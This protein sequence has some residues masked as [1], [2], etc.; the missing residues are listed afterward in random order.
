MTHSPSSRLAEFAST[1]HYDDIPGEVVERTQWLFLDWYA[2]AVAGCNARSPVVFKKFAREMG[3]QSGPCEIIGGGPGSSALFAA[4]ANGAASH[5]VEQDDLH[6]SSIL[7]PATVVFP[8]ILA[9]AQAD[10][11]ISGRDFLVA[12][13]AGY[14][15]GIRVGEFL[16][17][18]HYRIFHM[19]GTAGTIASAMAAGRLLGLDPDRML[20]A[21]GSA[22]TQAAGLWEFLK[23]AADSKQLHTAKACAD[24][25]VA[26]WTAQAGLTGAGTILEGTQ[27]MASGMMGG[28]D[29]GKITDRLGSRW[30]LME[31]SFKYHASCRHTHPA[32]DAMLKLREDRRFEMED[33]ASVDSYVYRAAK[34]VLGAVDVP[35]TIHQSKFS[36]GFVLA[37]IAQ[38]G[39]AGVDD[40]SEQALNDPEI[41]RFREKVSM[42][43]DDEIEG[44]YPERWGTR[45]E[46]AL[47]S[48]ETLSCFVDNPKGD[49]DNMLKREE[50]ED[51]V[52]RLVRYG[53]V[54][55]QE[56]IDNIIQSVWKLTEK[57][58][59]TS[60]FC[61]MI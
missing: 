9:L 16:G 17:P 51:K 32:A 19:T 47:R 58:S 6:N 35:E 4:M 54:E 11:R 53:G 45:V 18:S 22:G 14:E 61:P 44:H 28:G 27:G 31:T 40:F 48:G 15:C 38:R 2:S 12:A 50:L 46:V 5:V 34:D 21:L 7:H 24:G 39:T 25:I 42:S 8:P 1:L 52:S 59:F 37:L 33:V 3:P 26:A 36:M 29:T 20:D 56:K 43:I 49:P 23:D 13:V 55:D 60:G 10:R 57:Q 30:A 41:A